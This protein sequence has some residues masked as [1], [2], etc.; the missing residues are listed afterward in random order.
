LSIKNSLEKGEVI[1]REGKKQT[2]SIRF[3]VLEACEEW[4][5]FNFILFSQFIA[6]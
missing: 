1:V 4:H 6:Y 3:F 2:N 5:V